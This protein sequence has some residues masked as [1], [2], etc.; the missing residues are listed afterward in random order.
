MVIE[1]KDKEN[2]KTIFAKHGEIVSTKTLRENGIYDK[3]IKRYIDEGVIEKV[4]RGYYR[5]TKSSNA[6]SDMP[7]IAALFPDG[8]LCLES[9]IDYY[10]YTD[11]TPNA[12]EIAVDKKSSR[13]RC[14]IEYPK[15]NVHYI[16][17][18]KFQIGI[19][20]VSIDGADVKIYDRERT[21]CDFLL[22]KNK[23]DAEVFNQAIQGYLKDTNK[24]E[25]VL[26]EY[27]PKLRVERKVR[28][29]LGIWL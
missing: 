1:L 22:H 15:I 17:S 7:V 10:G 28:E 5:Y 19:T 16:E 2:L 4:R 18:E 12:W 9:A 14:K 3:K 29:V 11:R 8:V 6:F 20:T 24:R 21:I 23:I 26:A 25:S 13:V 27:A